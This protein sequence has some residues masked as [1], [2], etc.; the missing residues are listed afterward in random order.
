MTSSGYNLE[1]GMFVLPVEVRI[2]AARINPSPPGIFKSSITAS[3][4]QYRVYR[5]EL[6]QCHL[7]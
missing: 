5:H 2:L 7:S 4:S 3:P 6:T 1:I